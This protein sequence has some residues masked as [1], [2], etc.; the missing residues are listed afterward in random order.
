[1]T[2]AVRVINYTGSVNTCYLPRN[3]TSVKHPLKLIGTARNRRPQQPL[4]DREREWGRES[5]KKRYKK[6]G[7]K[8]KMGD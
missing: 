3:S 2:G 6:R 8:M 1:M 7:R 4:R 5:G